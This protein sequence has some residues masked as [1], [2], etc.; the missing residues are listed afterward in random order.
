MREICFVLVP[1]FP[2]YAL[3]PAIEALRLA[4]QNAGTTLYD[5]VFASCDGGPVTAGNGMVIEATQ[6]LSSTLTQSFAIVCA[7]NDPTRMLQREL[8]DWLHRRAV[9][10]TRLGALDTGTFA[11][12][13]AGVLTGYRVTLHWEA[14]PAY[15]DLYPNA[16][17]VEE[18]FVV[19]RGRWTCAGGTA[20]LDMMLHLIEEDHGPALAQIVANGFVHGRGR[21]S[22]TPQR[23]VAG[24]AAPPIWLKVSRLMAEH[25]SYPLPIEELCVRSGASRRTVERLFQRASGVSPATHYLWLRLDKARDQ[26]FYTDETISHI[27]EVTGF[28]SSAHFSRAFKERYGATPSAFRRS[29]SA[30]RRH[31]YHPVG[32]RISRQDRS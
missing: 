15:R 20:A 5:W 17:V 19:D 26:L 6:P 22:N 12:A 1:E 24:D 7:G 32:L 27:A 8:L 4:N 2:L 30:E 14:I 10:G 31:L 16:D 21:P 11:L 18:L 3:V 23:A 25:I 29:S 13:A 28:Q 9:F